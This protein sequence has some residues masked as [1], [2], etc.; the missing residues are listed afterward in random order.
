MTI[1]TVMI[2]VWDCPTGPFEH[3]GIRAASYWKLKYVY[4]SGSNPLRLGL[5]G[6]LE[7]ERPP[8]FRI[9]VTETLSKFEG[10][11]FHHLHIVLAIAINVQQCVVSIFSDRANVN[12]AAFW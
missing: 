4:A 2:S 1:P 5:T 6:R 9:S 12:M 3:A 7:T 8:D 11:P 10:Q